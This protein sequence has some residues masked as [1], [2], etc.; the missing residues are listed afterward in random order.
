MQS[1]IFDPQ[2]GQ[3]TCRPLAGVCVAM[4]ILYEEGKWRPEDPIARYIPEFSE[5]KVLAPSGT[6]EAPAHAPT[7]GEL[8]THS[9]GTTYGGLGGATAVD[10]L[11]VDARLTESASL[12]SS[13]L[14]LGRS[15][16]RTIPGT[17]GLTAT[18][19]TSRGISSRSC[20]GNRYQISC[21]NGSSSR[22]G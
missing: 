14:S 21:G 19:W 3:G 20:P 6:L 22:S 7:I 5:L 4:M 17:G 1:G 9:A 11:Y 18:R 10:K 16:S 8:M 13:S 2:G 12:G 15:R